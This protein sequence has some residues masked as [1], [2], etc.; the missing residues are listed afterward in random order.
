MNLVIGSIVN[1]SI[2]ARSSLYSSV[3]ICTKI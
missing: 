1:Q 3:I 2:K